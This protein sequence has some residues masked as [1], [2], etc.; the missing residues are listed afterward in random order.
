MEKKSPPPLFG[1]RWT[2]GGILSLSDV[3]KS[4]WPFMH[5]AYLLLGDYP[6]TIIFSVSSDFVYPSS[7]L[8]ILFTIGDPP[9]TPATRTTALLS[10]ESA[11]FS[12]LF[13]RVHYF[14]F[15][16]MPERQIAFCLVSWRPPLLLIRRGAHKFTNFH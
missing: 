1:L 6:K 12:I 13:S 7:V 9:F 8:I 10:L 2:H 5:S 4:G 3:A 11:I 14:R 15:S 16:S